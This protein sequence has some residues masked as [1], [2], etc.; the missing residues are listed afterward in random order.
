MTADQLYEKGFEAR[1]NGDYPTAS[2]W[3]NRALQ[4]DPDHSN[5]MWQLAIIKGFE[6]DFDG[7]IA[8]LK[9]VV[10]KSPTHEKAW[11][12]LGMSCTMLME[13]PDAVNAFQRVLQ[14]NPGNED[15]MRQLDMLKD[16]M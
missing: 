11:Y 12:D 2:E 16:Y 10:A 9:D 15:A 13:I 14:L 1:C 3:L 7:S 4:I 5:A 6:G 8:A